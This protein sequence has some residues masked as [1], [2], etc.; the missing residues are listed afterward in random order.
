M[1]TRTTR[2]LRG[3]IVMAA[4]MTLLAALVPAAADATTSARMDRNSVQITDSFQVVFETDQD[5]SSRPDFSALSDDFDVLGTSQS[6]SVNIV[7]GRMQRSARWIVDLMAKRE[8]V[9]TI[10]SIAIGNEQSS[11]LTVT[12]KPSTATGS[13]ATGD[14]FMEVEVDTPAP[15]VQQQVVLTIRLFRAVQT[16]NAS[17]T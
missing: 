17:L 9:F 2:C 13:G 6:T 10:P 8:G 3:G 7:N 15:Y 5:V 1:V 4:T 16:G 12:V 11:P 14:V